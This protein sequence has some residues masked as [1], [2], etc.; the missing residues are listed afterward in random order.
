MR[1]NLGVGRTERRATP[2]HQGDRPT[3]GNATF[4]FRNVTTLT[5]AYLALQL[6]LLFKICD[7]RGLLEQEN[8]F[9]I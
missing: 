5:V 6:V 4:Y 9:A 8:V 2:S 7:V 3:H 1:E